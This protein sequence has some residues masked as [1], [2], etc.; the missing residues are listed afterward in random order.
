MIINFWF[1]GVEIILFLLKAFHAVLNE[2]KTINRNLCFEEINV[3]QSLEVEH[4]GIC[5][6]SLT[7]VAGFSS[8][9]IRY[10]GLYI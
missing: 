3:N 8:N 9:Y 10:F 5:R 4:E 2:E 7:I 6:I 1:G